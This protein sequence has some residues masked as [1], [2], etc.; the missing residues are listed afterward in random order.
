MTEDQRLVAEAMYAVDA[1]SA[2]HWP[3]VANV[4][5]DEVDRLTATAAAMRAGVVPE[6][7]RLRA[8]EIAAR[9]YTLALDD[10]MFGD[11]RGALRMLRASLKGT[12]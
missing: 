2:G 6:L 4:L 3:T 11:P 5:A 10:D 12:S 8:V 7:E 1:K 9:A